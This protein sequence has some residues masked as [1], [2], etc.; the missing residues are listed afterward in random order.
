MRSDLLISNIPFYIPCLLSHIICELAVW[1][2]CIFFTLQGRAM[3]Y[4]TTWMLMINRHM[5]PEE[6]FGQHQ[7]TLITD[8]HITK[9]HI[10]ILYIHIVHTYTQ[11]CIYIMDA[12]AKVYT[13]PKGLTAQT[14]KQKLVRTN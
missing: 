10:S 12:S 1:F 8:A 3:R 7:Q 6:K 14:T 2:A 5:I 13:V 9:S 11:I 4:D